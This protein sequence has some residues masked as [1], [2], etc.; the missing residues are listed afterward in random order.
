MWRESDADEKA[1]VTTRPAT[2]L[3]CDATLLQATSDTQKLVGIG[4]TDIVAVAM[5]DAV[6]V[7]HKDRAQDV[8]EAVAL[9]KANGISQATTLPRDYR[10]WGWYESLVIGPRF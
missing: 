1:V 6:L 5:P 8:K 9:L 3:D 10:P 4:L 7:A 2:A